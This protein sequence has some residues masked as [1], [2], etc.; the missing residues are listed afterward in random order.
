MSSNQGQNQGQNQSPYQKPNQYQYQ[1]S[2]LQYQTQSQ[3][4][5]HQNQLPSQNTSAGTTPV[6][7]P[8]SVASSATQVKSEQD[9][10]ERLAL[11]FA[12]LP[13]REMPPE[14]SDPV[15]AQQQQQQLTNAASRAVPDHKI[16]PNTPTNN[17]VAKTIRAAMADIKPS[18]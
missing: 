18:S 2:N 3:Y 12:S 17:F 4:Q 16:S 9:C 5:Q 7:V 14:V 8:P 11:E 13:D 10:F 6:M 15:A 1:S